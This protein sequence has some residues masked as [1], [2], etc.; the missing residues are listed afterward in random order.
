M[1]TEIIRGIAPAPRAYLRRIGMKEALCS[2]IG[3][4][5]CCNPGTERVLILAEQ[6]AQLDIHLSCLSERK[7]G[8]EV[9]MMS[10]KRAATLH[11]PTSLWFL[12]D[13]DQLH[14][15]CCNSPPRERELATKR[16]PAEFPS[17]TPS[18]IL[19]FHARPG[20]RFFSDAPAV[21]LVKFQRESR[22]SS[23][24]RDDR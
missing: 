19:H 21:L 20:V 15:F 4:A 18:I 7:G 24:H 3:S 11:K 10:Q 9:R 12:H 17:S 8:A 16:R 2:L 1:E 13:C 5:A 23:F 22:L 6:T 14:L